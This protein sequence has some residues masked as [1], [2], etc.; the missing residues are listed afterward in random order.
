MRYNIKLYLLLILIIIPL[1]SII[2]R[3]NSYDSSIYIDNPAYQD[4][5]LQNASTFLSISLPELI[6][7]NRDKALQEFLSNFEALKQISV[8]DLLSTYNQL[9]SF[10]GNYITLDSLLIINP[11][12]L[13]DVQTLLIYYYIQI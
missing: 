4:S 11:R 8:K 10:D 9:Y 5:I 6:V 2:A 1:N 3:E 7:E 12:Y 13:E